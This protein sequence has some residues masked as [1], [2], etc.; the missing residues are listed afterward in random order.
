MV[1]HIVNCIS[2]I[3]RIRTIRITSKAC[4][5]SFLSSHSLRYFGTPSLELCRLHLGS[6][7]HEAE[8]IRAR[9]GWEFRESSRVVSCHQGEGTAKVEFPVEIYRALQGKACQ[10]GTDPLRV[11]AT[12]LGG[13]SKS[14]LTVPKPNSGLKSAVGPC[15]FSDMV[16]IRASAIATH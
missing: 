9:L 12:A 4:K 3:R 10:L 15:S 7:E 13:A 8:D 16:A 2:F 1:D 6:V 11:G 5:T 14:P